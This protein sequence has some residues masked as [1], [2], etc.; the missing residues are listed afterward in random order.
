MRRITPKE[1]VIATAITSLVIAEL[2]YSACSSTGWWWPTVVLSLVYLS[3][4]VFTVFQQVKNP[5]AA[6]FMMRAWVIPS[7]CMG[8]F[9]W[10]FGYAAGR[11]AFDIHTLLTRR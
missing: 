9:A 7:A 2:L 1:V 5:T 11:G 6:Q 8:L 4:T 10:L 3:G